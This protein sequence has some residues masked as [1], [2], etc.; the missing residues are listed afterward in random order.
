VNNDAVSSPG[1]VDNKPQKAPQEDDSH[2]SADRD[3]DEKCKAGAGKIEEA[4]KDD[5]QP[6]KKKESD[7]NEIINAQHEDRAEA[8][9]TRHQHLR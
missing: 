9:G 8:V 6:R 5:E 2:P 4:V 7:R 3:D 1:A